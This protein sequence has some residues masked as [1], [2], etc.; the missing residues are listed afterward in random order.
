[1]L[2]RSAKRDLF[3]LAKDDFVKAIQRARSIRHNAVMIYGHPNANATSSQGKCT[4][5]IEAAIHKLV[6]IK[7]N[8]RKW[9]LYSMLMEGRKLSRGGNCHVP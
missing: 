7:L 2:F 4:W 8:A 6:A 3:M 1:M 9:I 5:M